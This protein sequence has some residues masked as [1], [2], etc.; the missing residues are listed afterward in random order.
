[1]DPRMAGLDHGV[2][3]RLK[4]L[5]VVLGSEG[6]LLPFV[7]LADALAEYGHRLVLAGFEEFSQRFDRGSVEY[8]G[9]P[10]DCQSMMK[11]LLGDSKGVLDIIR[12]IREIVGD[13]ETFEV[14]EGAMDGVDLVMYTQF[15]EVASLFAVAHGVPSIR[16]QVFPTEPCFRYSLVDPRNLDGTIGALVTHL[17]S[18]ALMRWAMRPVMTTWKRRLGVRRGAVSAKQTTLYQFS[19]FLSPP[20]PEW[21]AHIHVTGEWL[22]PAVDS[23][24]LSPLVE[25]FL[26]TGEAPLLVSFGSVVTERRENLLRW[27]RDAV[28][29]QGLRAI[30]VDPDHEPGVTGGIL[31]VS[32]VPFNSVLPRCLAGFCHGSLGTTGAILRAG[33]PCLSVAFGG[34]QHFHANAVCRNGAGPNYIDAQRGELSAKT[35]AD[36][37]A[38]LVSG[39]YDRAAR[40]L[41]QSLANDPGTDAVVQVVIGLGAQTFGHKNSGYRMKEGK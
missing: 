12:G 4:V 33:K 3:V 5:A 21:K 29:N 15:S 6:D 2:S 37:I 8:I 11:R 18:N 41:M 30:I 36:G 28:D 34:D 13:P 17:V 7:H 24:P 16:V 35:V 25:E 32:R 14:L 27:T 20:A 9:I 39:E 19:P 38:D 1:M 23:E 10:G 26:S 40:D 22:P 31:T